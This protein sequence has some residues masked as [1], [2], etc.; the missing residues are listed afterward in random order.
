MR[1]AL[2]VVGVL[3]VAACGAPPT[4]LPTS[5]PPHISTPAPNWPRPD[6]S[7]REFE[8]RYSD[9]GVPSPTDTFQGPNSLAGLFDLASSLMKET[10]LR[11]PEPDV[12]EASTIFPGKSVPR[13][14]RLKL[15]DR[16]TCKDGTLRKHF[17]A[18]TTTTKTEYELI[19]YL[20]ETGALLAVQRYRISGTNLITRLQAY[21][22]ERW[23]LFERISSNVGYTHNPALQRT[24]LRRA[25]EL[26][27]YA[28]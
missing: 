14:V 17:I 15:G 13:T 6:A 4:A 7:C 26:A 22:E 5:P 18:E 9:K 27:R 1:L 11:F 10:V 25:A 19:L 16:F 23:F 3:I 21:I 8:G 12:I 2:S 24:R 28:S 20:T